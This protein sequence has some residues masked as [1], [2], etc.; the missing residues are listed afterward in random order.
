MTTEQASAQAYLADARNEDVLVYVNGAFVPRNEARG[1]GVRLGLRAG[2]RRV[3]RA[4]PGEGQADQPGRPS[5]PAVR[6]RALDR[7]STSA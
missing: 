6:G 4:A 1:V 7:S 3:G 5:R 2:R